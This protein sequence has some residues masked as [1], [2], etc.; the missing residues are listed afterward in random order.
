MD[1]DKFLEHFEMS[2]RGKHFD[3]E[4]TERILNGEKCRDS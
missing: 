3:K 4:Q 2:L 1:F